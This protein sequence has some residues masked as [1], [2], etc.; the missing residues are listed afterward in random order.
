MNALLR[1]AASLFLAASTLLAS[2]GASGRWPGQVGRAEATGA[3]FVV[4]TI[5]DDGP[6]SLRQAIAGA[7]AAPGADTIVFAIGGCPSACTIA[8]ASPLPSI[9]QP[10]AIDGTTQPGGPLIVL[11]GANAGPGAHGLVVEA[12]GA[13]SSIRGLAVNGFQGAGILLAGGAAGSTVA[14]N[15]LG[16]DASGA[17]ALPNGT[18]VQITN[19]SNN[20]IGGPTAA[21]RNLI[22]GNTFKGVSIT[23]SGGPASGNTVKGNYIGTG[24]S[25]DTVLGN[26]VGISII[27]ASGNTIGGANTGE[28]NL[29]AGNKH[30]VAIKGTSGSGSAN[31]TL[32]NNRIGSNGTVA[33]RAP[34]AAS[35]GV[36][37]DGSSAPAANNLIVA[38]SIAGNGTQ[39][40]WV[41][42]AG[43]TGN[44]LHGNTIGDANIPALGNLREGVLITNGA[45][46]NVIGGL[47]P[48]LANVIARN[49]S[50]GNTATGD[51]A[52]G[53][54]VGSGT[55][56]A[57]RG[58]SIT[59]NAGLGIDLGA[60]EAGNGV[61]NNDD[62]DPD[63]GANN[64]QNF[65]VLSIA[66]TNRGTTLKLFGLLNSTPTTSFAVDFYSNAACDSS[67]RGEGATYLGSTVVDT[68]G[69]GN[70]AI[71]LSLT[72]A[73]SVQAGEQI[74]ATATDPAGSTSEFS[75]CLGAIAVPSPPTNVSATG[76]NEQAQVTWAP[77]VDNGGS[78][79]TSYTVTAFS[80]GTP[81]G[82]KVTV[83]GD[84]GIAIVA[85]LAN[86]Q[87]YSF[88]VHATNAAGDGAESSPSNPVIPSAGAGVTLR[89]QP[90][91]V[92]VATGTTVDVAVV[93]QAGEQQLDGAEAVLR[94]DPAVVAVVDADLS[95]DGVQLVADADGNPGNG[96]QVAV[97]PGLGLP[98]CG[99]P[100]EVANRASGDGVIHLARGA[101][102]SENDPGPPIDGTCV[103]GTIRLRGLAVAD[104]V[105]MPLRFQLLPDLP[106]S[107]AALQGQ[108]LP[109][110]TADGAVSVFPKHLSF[111]AQPPRAAQGFAFGIQPVVKVL[112]DTAPAGDGT[113]VTLGLRAVPGA[114]SPAAVLSCAGDSAH[115]ILAGLTQTVAGGAASFGGCSVD[116]RGSYRLEAASSAADVLGAVSDA[117]PVRYPGDGDGNCL[118]DIVDFSLLLRA[119]G[120]HLLDLLF[121]PGVDFNGDNGVDIVDFSILLSRFGTHC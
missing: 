117:F 116:L 31:N 82:P 51:G 48:G 67:G 69:A 95:A 1:A 111:F 75:P 37:V 5:G 109:L 18:G 33:L 70:A 35:A 6:G 97:A 63:A 43:A 106:G 88:S 93:L 112:H 36:E 32:R 96:L 15:Y 74:T 103:L 113:T 57:I 68:D 62:K 20:T 38:N 105:T 54:T 110:T 55:G 30:N 78:A 84:V 19:S 118:V 72:A 7:N 10:L 119:F 22:S 59:A 41:H 39:G 99:L 81:A 100:A 90:S 34:A 66:G 45:S 120:T 11:A 76:G 101:Q 86:G 115:G 85:G 2:G 98:D 28:R 121:N 29:I 83:G 114:G 16:T 4:S 27:D 24:P 108:A 47:A 21:D 56:N 87:S 3:T 79:I 104:R 61:T 46:G 80:G 60:G 40:V 13:G 58:N 64:L 8:L 65:P 25:G 26:E 14:G 12:G 44:S 9:T 49:G 71:N 89:L 17:S 107:G 92:S 77:P 73:A 94:F 91:A 42:G 23:G 52:A 50:A 102:I 53:V